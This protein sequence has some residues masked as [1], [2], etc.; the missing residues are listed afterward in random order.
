VN[1]RT[2]AVITVIGGF[3]IFGLKLLAFTISGS[4][5][6]LSDAL[7]SIVNI[8]ASILMFF[9]VKISGKPADFDHN[10]GHEKIENISAFIE[11][12]LVII[13]ALLIVYTAIGRLR[14]PTFELLELNIAVGLSF[15]AMFSN[16]GLSLLLRKTANNTGSM[17]LEGDSK[18][19]LSDVFSSV[20]VNVGLIVANVT[21]LKILDPLLA[22]M[23]AFLVGKMGIELILKSGKYLMDTSADGEQE[24]IESL[25]KDHKPKFINYHNVKTRKSGSKVFAELHLTVDP[26]LTVQEAHDFTKH[27]EEDIHQKMPEV[28]ITIHVEPPKAHSDVD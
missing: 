8:V 4:I 28:C 23:V 7:E 14:N 5:A 25:L 10:Y 18:H 16:L 12:V 2:V 26:N 19:L 17:A 11:G 24:K 22:L 9:S 6:L 1:K 3:V 15:L 27:L 13:A 21:G 20:A